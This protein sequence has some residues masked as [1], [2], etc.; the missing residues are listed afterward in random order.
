V[1]TVAMPLLSYLQHMFS[2]INAF[3]YSFV[4]LHHNPVLLV[5][6]KDN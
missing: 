3:F 2:F 4:D 6:N 5:F 1:K